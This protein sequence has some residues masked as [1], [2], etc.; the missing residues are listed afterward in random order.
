M[1]TTYPRIHIYVLI[2]LTVL[3]LAL[4]LLPALWKILREFNKMVA[5]RQRWIA[6]RCE[7]KEMAWLSA[8]DAPAFMEWGEKR[9]KAFLLK[10]GLSNSFELNGNQRNGSR[11]RGPR[12]RGQG[13]AG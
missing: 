5:Y 11:R 3:V 12:E 2:I 9:L 7:G 13:R 6:V 10:T 8:K 1:E 4:A